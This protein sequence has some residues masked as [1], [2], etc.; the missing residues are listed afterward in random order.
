[1]ILPNS[2]MQHALPARWA[3]LAKS[4]VPDAIFVH[5]PL[6][7]P[8]SPYALGRPGETDAFPNFT[9]ETLAK[10]LPGDRANR[11][12]RDANFIAVYRAQ[13][14]RMRASGK[15]VCGVVERA[16]SR[17]P[18][19]LSKA[20]LTLLEHSSFIDAASQRQMQDKL[21]D[22][23][24]GDTVLFEC[25]L[26]EGEFVSPIEVDKQEKSKIPEAWE[27]EIEGYPKPLITF[28]KAHGEAMPLR[29]EAFPNGKLEVDDVVQLVLHM[30]RLLP[31]YSFP[32]GLDI[33]DKYA[34]VTEWMSRQMNTMLSAQLMSK[35]LESGNPATIRLVKRVLCSNVRDWLFRPDFQR[36]N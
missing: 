26:E 32:V 29:I 23:S 34:K 9:P 24:I 2:A 13:L 33:V 31:R 8:V 27:I 16:A 35:A 19:I 36:G 22:Y 1:M 18:G 4:P 5:G 25:V 21:R 30:S 15:T 6:V 3:L 28:L 11:T 14:E 7:N 17:A 10:L 12:G 20:L